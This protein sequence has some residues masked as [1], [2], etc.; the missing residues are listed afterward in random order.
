MRTGTTR[1]QFSSLST[2]V[3]RHAPTSNSA[4]TLGFER[5][6]ERLVLSHAVAAAELWPIHTA[7]APFDDAAPAAELVRVLAQDGDSRADAIELDTLRGTRE[8]WGAVGGADPRDYYRFELSGESAV[9]IALGGLTQDID[10]YL[11]D[12]AGHPLAQSIRAGA[13]SESLARTLGAGTY[14]VLVAPFGNHASAYRLTLEATAQ[15][16]PADG[17]G[18]TLRDASD[19]G[20]IEDARVVQDAVGGNDPADYYRFQLDGD[21]TVDLQLSGLRSDVDLYL[22]GEDG[23]E[24]ARSWKGGSSDESIHVS[25]AAGQYYVLAKP[26]GAAESPYRLSISAEP[27]S[28]SPDPNPQPPPATPSPDPEPDPAPDPAPGQTE[29]YPDVAD[30]GGANDWNLNRVGAPESWAQ[31]I[32]GEGVVV[33]VVDTGVDT[34]HRELSSSIWVNSGE[35]PG[36]GRDDDHNGFVDDVAGWD[37]VDDDNNASDENGHGTHVA[38]T[39]AAANDGYGSTGI[40][41][42]A[43]IM[44]I[45]VLDGDGSGLI[46]DVAA[47]IRYAVDN[48]AD[49]INLSLGGGYSSALRSALAYAD[50]NGVFVVAAAGNESAATPAYPAAFSAELTNVLSVGAHDAYDAI[51]S[52]SNRVGAGGAVQV[53]APGVG[54]YS[55]LPGN[56]YGRYS[57]TSMAAPHVAG[58][59]ALA[60][61]ANPGLDPA[62]LRSI[63]VEGADRAIANTDSVGGVNGARSTALAAA[64]ANAA[65]VD[66][67]MADFGG[68]AATT[69]RDAFSIWDLAW[70]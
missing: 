16:A 63:L 64:R 33:A 3:R 13:Q 55:T 34:G 69:R 70:T 12:S 54:I 52:F 50:Q 21:G 9:E 60:L 7:P 23:R 8:L 57:G 40:A 15:T 27:A 67:L 1:R 35:I 58:L 65:T 45:R 47:G 46:S 49:I 36:N 56:R 29:P 20:M 26:W 31:G 18:D 66:R 43:A 22:Y 48:G 28:P 25:L 10:L 19:L 41:Y 14:F 61:C 11:L 62:A 42:G 32:T 39:I 38:G 53:D 6:E 4:T 59:A 17:A 24:L 2:R 37:F 44:A 5:L 68:S 30:F 51:A